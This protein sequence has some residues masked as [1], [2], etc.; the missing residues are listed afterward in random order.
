MTFYSEAFGVRFRVVKTRG[1]CGE[2][3]LRDR[4][5]ERLF[6]TL[7]TSLAAGVNAVLIWFRKRC[8]SGSTFSSARCP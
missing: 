2:S 4:L 7:A 5:R 8:P 3:Q 6:A 1:A